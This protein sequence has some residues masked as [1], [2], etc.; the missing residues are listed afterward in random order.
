M[1]VKCEQRLLND[2]RLYLPSL[3]MKRPSH[4]DV[5]RNEDNGWRIICFRV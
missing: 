1:R 4:E 3:A 5:R 2:V